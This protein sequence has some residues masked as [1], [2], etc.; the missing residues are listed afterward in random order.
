MADL[1]KFTVVYTVDADTGRAK[2]QAYDPSGETAPALADGHSIQGVAMTDSNADDPVAV[3][4][5]G[6]M[7]N[8][9][10]T[11]LTGWEP[12][13]GDLLW[14]GASGKPTTTRPTDD[15]A[16]VFVGTYIGNGVVDVDVKLLPSL[17]ELTFVKRETPA[18]YDVLIYDTGTSL[19][20]PRQIDHGQ[21][22]AGLGDDDHT[23]YQLRSEKSMDSGYP[24]LDGSR[25]VPTGEMATGAAS[26][27]VFLRGDRTWSEL[28]AVLRLSTGLQQED[29]LQLVK[30]ERQLGWAAPT[31]TADRTTFV[32]S[33][34]TLE[35]LAQRVKALVDDLTTHGLI[36]P[37]VV[38]PGAILDGATLYPPTVALA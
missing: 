32:T 30:A 37:D 4:R 33:T 10:S 20:V 12:S 34:V 1:A 2:V 8:L 35:E 21:D 38:V 9:N 15:A 22:L 18:L 26:A 23:Q 27:A 5:R 14:C 31:G 19:W 13:V 3:M 17:Q 16:Q 36:G 6:Y 28:L 7:R 24:T 11:H 25:L 29:G